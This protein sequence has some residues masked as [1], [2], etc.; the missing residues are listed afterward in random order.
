MSRKFWISD[1]SGLD[2]SAAFRSTNYDV[3]YLQ[4]T[5]WRP[6]QLAEIVRS[7][8]ITI[9]SCDEDGVYPTGVLGRVGQLNSNRMELFALFSRENAQVEI[10]RDVLV[11]DGAGGSTLETWTGYAQSSSTIVPDTPEDF[12]SYQTVG[13]DLLFADPIWYG[14]AL[15]P[16]VAGTDTV[17]NPGTVDATN[18]VLTF[19]GGA[20]YRLTNQT[21][22][23]DRWVQVD[24]SG[25]IIVDVRAGTATKAGANII[26]KLSKYGGREF[27]ALVPGDNTMVLT[28]GGSVQIAFSTPRG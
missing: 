16:S 21:T 12:D 15:T 25:T 22:D 6:K 3:A 8:A 7:I 20:N 24:D 18:L 4:G 11:S 27:M 19:T 2:A 14:A 5:M 10:Q 13:V 17:N 23:P 9:D 28:G 26:G 1:R